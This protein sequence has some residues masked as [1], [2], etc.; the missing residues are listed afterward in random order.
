MKDIK[1]PKLL[2]NCNVDS[3]SMLYARL[4]KCVNKNGLIRKL[5]FKIDKP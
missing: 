2:S 4:K 5:K 1:L 3:I